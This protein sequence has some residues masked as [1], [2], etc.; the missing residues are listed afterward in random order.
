MRRTLALFPVL[1]I[2]IGCSPSER[3]PLASVDAPGIRVVLG[4]RPHEMEL[5]TIPLLRQDDG[6]P[7]VQSYDVVFTVTRGHSHEIELKYDD[8]TGELEDFLEL[9]FGENTLLQWPDGTPIED[10]ESVDITLT[11]DPSTFLF[12]LSPAGLVL[13]ASDPLRI[14]VDYEHANPDFNGDGLVDELDEQIR[15]QLGWWR[16]DEPA[17]WTALETIHDL[18]EQSLRSQTDILE[19][20]AVSW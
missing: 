10:G 7:A 5:R 11:V 4:N 19:N 16:Q 6:A 3:S 8:G 14:E 2:S 9:K 20:I 13:S 1:W 17:L 12:D 18:P 15:E